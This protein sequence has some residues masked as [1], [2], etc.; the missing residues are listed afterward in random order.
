MFMPCRLADTSNCRRF[1]GWQTLRIHRP[2]HEGT[3]TKSEEYIPEMATR[4]YKK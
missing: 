3:K 4:Q 2:E 1:E